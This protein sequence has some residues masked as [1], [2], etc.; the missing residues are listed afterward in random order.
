MKLLSSFLNEELIR[1]H[2]E[3]IYSSYGR[4]HLLE[5]DE[6]TTREAAFMD[7]YDEAG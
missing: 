3:G 5:D 4:Q 2:E 1:E 7:G 6:L